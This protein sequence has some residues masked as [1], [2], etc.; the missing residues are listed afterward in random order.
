[1]GESD[2]QLR[3]DEPPESPAVEN[4]KPIER[5]PGDTSGSSESLDVTDEEMRQ[6]FEEFERDHHKISQELFGEESTFS[7]PLPDRHF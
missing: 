1:M 4:T 3:L 6:A 7:G 2:P 5:R